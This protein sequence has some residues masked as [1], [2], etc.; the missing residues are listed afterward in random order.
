MQLLS[1]IVHVDFIALIAVLYL[2]IFIHF[3]RA[4]DKK[5]SGPYIRTLLLLALLVISD[6]VDYHYSELPYPSPAHPYF[7]MAGYMLRVF[8]I[9]AAIFIV[10]GNALPKKKIALLSI[11][12]ILNTLVILTAPVNKMVF[13]IDESNVLHREI[14]SY[15]P[16]VVSG[17][18]FIL[19]V[20]MTVQR[21]RKGFLEEGL[22]LTVS[23][24][25]ILFAVVAEIVLKTRGLL[26]SA[27]LMMLAFYYLYLHMEHF[28]RDTLT[29]AFN[30]MSFFAD[31]ER[32]H[33][34][35]ITAMCEIDMNNLKL[36]N[37]SLGHA[38]GDTAITT[39]AHAI[40]TCLPSQCRLYR[41]GGDEFAVL[42]YSMEA[43]KCTEIINLIRA[44]IAKTSYSCAIGIAFWD[45]N[46]DFQ[47]VYNLADSRMYEDKRRIKQGQA[48]I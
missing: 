20:I 46:Q 32:T 8:L 11:P 2:V 34:G 33:P 35:T 13:W 16:H 45:V 25:S 22:L 39:V 28:K 44:E 24:I 9:L 41:L 42:F 10:S 43:Q 23:L 1:Q 27:I 48:T 29:G 21:Y 3:N 31:L 14:L 40:Q 38:S 4:Y 12:A 26:I 37:D 15:V 18:Y 30:R 7:I 6:N 47:Q 19:V 36:I 5:I 17:I